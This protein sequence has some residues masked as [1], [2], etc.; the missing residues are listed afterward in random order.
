MEQSI[1]RSKKLKT[2]ANRSMRILVVLLL[3]SILAGTL[4]TSIALAAAP[5]MN[6][7]LQSTERA[8]ALLAQMNNTQKVAMVHGASGSYVG[9]V[10]AISA[11]GIP[12]LNLS[13]GPAGAGNG[14]TNVTA[15]PVPIT[16]ASS[17]DVNLMRQFGIYMGAEQLG[18]G[19]NVVLAP[20]M[21]ITRVPLGGRNWEGY[22]EDP[23]LSE[24]MAY[25]EVLGIQSNG[26]IATAKHYIDNEQETNRNSYSVTVDDRTQHEIYW[27]PFRG[28]MQ[29]GVGAFMCAYNR[30]GGTYA[31]ENATTQNTLLKSQLGFPG[32]IMSDWGATHSTVASANNGLDMEMSGS[33]YFG[34]ALTTAVN[35][36]T[37]S[38]ARLNDMVRRI[39]ISMFAAGLFDRNPTGSRTANVRTTAHTQFARDASAQSLVLLRNN[40]NILPLT[41]SVNSIAVIGAQ[42]STSP[43]VGGGGSGAVQGGTTSTALA[44]ITSR[45]GSGVTI[46]YA[47]G[48]NSTTAANNA[49]A[50]D[51]AVVVVGLSSS[52]G[53]DRSS[54]NLPSGQDSL[55]S[56]VAAAN[57]NTIVVVYS[58]AQVLMPWNNSVAAVLWGGLPGEQQ[59]NALADVLFGDVNPSGKLPITF[60]SSSSN[61]PAAV[62]SSSTISY[63]EG[64]NVGY[65]H[66]DADSI[67]PMY[68]FGHGL[69]YTTF[70]YSNLSASASGTNVTA[71]VTVTNSGSR[72]GAE[73][74]Q[75]Y[76][77]FPSS[78]GEPPQVLRGFQKVSLA[79][80][81]SRTVTFSL[82]SEEL[83]YWNTSSGSWTVPS[84]TFTI[85]VGSSSR[86][87]RQ[88]TTV[89]VTGGGVITPSY[90]PTST[91]TGTATRTAT[92]T[93][94]GTATSVT[95]T[96]TR[97]PTLTATSVTNTFTRTPTRTA[98]SATNTF[99]R[100][101]TRTQTR[102]STP[103]T[104][105]GQSPYG[106]TAWAIPGT[107]QA[108][109]YDL[110][111]SGVAYNDTT[112][113]NS[114]GAYRSDYVDIEST[115]DT[116]GGYN[117]G[118]IAS[119]E[120]LEYSVN[121]A[122]S[123]S[124][125]IG[126]RVAASGTS[127]RTLYVAVD[128]T[129]VTGT[130]T[131]TST[132][133]YQVWTTVS[134]AGIPLTAG[135]HVVRIYM[136]SASFNL[137][138]VS[139]SLGA[140]SVTNT[141]TPTSNISLTPTRTYTNTPTS[142]VSLTPTATPST[143]TSQ[144]PYGG[145][146]WAVPGTIQAEDY[147]LGGSNV[148]YYDT[149]NSNS[150]GAYR[151]DY[152][153]I[154]STTDTGGGY[155]VGWI[156]SGEW[157]EYTVDVA[158]DGT[159]TI[160]LRVAASGTSSRTLYVAIDGTNV[161]GTITFTSTGGYQ[162][163]TTVSVTGIPLTAGQH[164]VRIY[165]S[166][167]SFNLNWISFTQ[168]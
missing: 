83:S 91:S 147:D 84:G 136:S 2:A 73:V 142:N 165:M 34:T 111:G 115:T 146:A 139:F 48:S 65:R 26:I 107:I 37:V 70:T 105:T 157:L 153:D 45:A 42:A 41:S 168:E 30:I 57:P 55:I 166:S 114:G 126:L 127:S 92:Q 82:T 123:G 27:A 116:G 40:N 106:G 32:W 71:S 7:L 133:G 86:D 63:S 35:N 69:S 150:G 78:A 59:G 74:V 121:V 19:T 43:V 162:V 51:V 163:W 102:T 8:D 112:T 28:A 75:L 20:M 77:G 99:T 148:A 6:A 161:T 104:P 15:F 31:C 67:T 29:A 113:S 44:G 38:Q 60:A 145:T 125:T 33:T 109:D 103:A 144:S 119:G 17:W 90:T 14:M 4:S 36:G 1:Y 100:T 160:N 87:I 52:E 3:V 158:A 47:D 24:E 39:L 50:A 56:A 129:N 61:Y 58:P 11:L 155:N 124:Y 128:D 154:E 22:G 66:F 72:A 89:Q 159:Y 94:T 138:W 98:T 117:V 149:T 95:N 167:A 141:P 16:V 164:V 62:S 68:A 134:V 152:V 137:N 12:A 88:T 9:N 143:P 93:Q 85:N 108:E 18:K 97:T 13:D 54:F 5:W 140:T 110:G 122:S 101:P 120:W 81:A 156:A 79:A 46:T 25:Y 64:L 96:F 10:P 53:S 118:W 76:L 49:A 130:I 135:P 21:N 23:Y 131:F 151:S 132:G 80:G